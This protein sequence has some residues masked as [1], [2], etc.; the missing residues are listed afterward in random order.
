M[1]YLKLPFT[2]LEMNFIDDLE[3]EQRGSSATIRTSPELNS[4][5]RTSLDDS[6]SLDG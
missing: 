1:N 2:V 3:Y 4:A 6:S 5:S